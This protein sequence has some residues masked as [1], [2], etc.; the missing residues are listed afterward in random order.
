[1]LFKN[2]NHLHFKV[3]YI[4]ISGEGNGTPLQ[5]S[6]LENPMDGG[7]WWAAV[8]GVAQSRTQLSDFT[9]TFHFHALEKEM[10]THSNV[11]AWRIP[12]MGKPGGLLSMGSHRVRRDWSDLAAV[13]YLYIRFLNMKHNK[14]V[15]STG[16]RNLLEH[17]DFLVSEF[18]ATEI[19]APISLQHSRKKMYVKSQRW[20]H[21]SACKLLISFI[22]VCLVAKSCL[23]LCY[24]MDCNLP[25]SS[26]FGI[27]QARILEWVP[28]PSAQDLPDPGIK[29]APSAL[30]SRFFNTEPPGKPS[31]T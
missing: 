23:T 15:L 9:S 10:A 26:V 25:G 4:S 14:F 31:I 30:A 8:H 1:M 6:C 2:H 22:C 29:S 11:L 7:A 27:F 16:W 24:P 17:V 28:F 21:D 13:A 18:Q 12:G 3:S 5:Y 20:I 19:L